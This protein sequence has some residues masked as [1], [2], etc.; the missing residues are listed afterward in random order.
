MNQTF[1]ECLHEPMPYDR[2]TPIKYLGTDPSNGRFG[3][4][5]I[6]RCNL[7]GRYWLRYSV[8]YEG[9]TAS[10]R[11]FMGLIAPDVADALRPDQA[12]EFL[13]SLDWHLYGGSYFGRKGKS[14]GSINADN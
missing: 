5:H 12:I 8:E 9:F 3:E 13:G 7:C 10:G 14:S 11:Y 2:Y 4:V 1:C 6:V